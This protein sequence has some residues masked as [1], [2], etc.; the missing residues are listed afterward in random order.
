MTKLMLLRVVVAA[1]DAA[2]FAD[3]ASRL[4]AVVEQL[5]TQSLTDGAEPLRV[6]WG[7]V[8]VTR[9]RQEKAP[10]RRKRTRTPAG[11]AEL[12]T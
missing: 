5:G 9:L 10:A 3:V 6:H 1:D 12:P 2:Q 4:R 11:Q 8:G 7:T